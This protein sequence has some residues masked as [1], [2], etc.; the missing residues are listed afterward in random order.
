M[1]LNVSSNGV[2]LYRIQLRFSETTKDAFEWA[3][4]RIL[5]EIFIT[6]LAKIFYVMSRQISEATSVKVSRGTTNQVI[7]N[8]YEAQTWE[9]F[10]FCILEMQEANKKKKRKQVTNI[11]SENSLNVERDSSQMGKKIAPNCE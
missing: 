6:F 8:V 9:N 1:A 2:E 10:Y 5:N 7:R 11:S 4:K 3:V